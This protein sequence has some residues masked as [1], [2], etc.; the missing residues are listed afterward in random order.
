MSIEEFLKNFNDIIPFTFQLK[1]GG[2][3]SNM[4]VTDKEFISR[5]NRKGRKCPSDC[6]NIFKVTTGYVSL[7]KMEIPVDLRVNC[8]HRNFFKWEEKPRVIGD[9]NVNFEVRILSED[10]TKQLGY[11]SLD[12][13][14]AGDI[15]HKFCSYY[16]EDGTHK[17]TQ[18]VAYSFDEKT[19]KTIPMEALSFTSKNPETGLE[20][21]VSFNKENGSLKC[22]T[23]TKQNPGEYSFGRITGPD[24]VSK[25]EEF[26]SKYSNDTL[27]THASP[28]VCDSMNYIINKDFT[29]NS[30][31]LNELKLLLA[32][33]DDSTSKPQYYENIRKEIM[34]LENP[35]NDPFKGFHGEYIGN[36]IVKI[37]SKL[38]L[39]VETLSGDYHYFT[40]IDI[41]GTDAF[42][43]DLSDDREDGTKYYQVIEE[44]DKM[45]SFRTKI[46]DGE[47]QLV[48]LYNISTTASE[49]NDYN[50]YKLYC[51]ESFGAI[52]RKGLSTLSLDKYSIGS[53]NY[54]LVKKG[55]K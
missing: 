24:D 1:I 16:N 14:P 23:V 21:I 50:I 30:E 53:S 29:Y 42:D 47:E 46:I 28:L 9:E 32:F 27:V 41:T 8:L 54:E 7:D 26:F 35:E 34:D 31:R 18:S 20:E 36:T 45:P 11:L 39:Y 37:G 48:P 12:L 25:K 49:E 33:R 6:N 44:A 55:L 51:K 5:K 2:E 38:I 22:V 4:I 43:L 17:I 19:K 40:C 52:E 10:K 15:S 13:T 3:S